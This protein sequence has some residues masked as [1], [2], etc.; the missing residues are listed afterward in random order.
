VRSV[1]TAGGRRRGQRGSITVLAVAMAAV[2]L[3]VGGTLAAAVGLVR[4][5][6]SAESAADLAAL[7]GARELEGARDGCVAAARIAAANDAR[8][9]SCRVD[10]SDVVVSV[11]VSGPHWL[12]L[13]ADLAAEARAGP[14]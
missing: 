11:T 12:G 4:A 9:T 14:G 2:L 8:L 3:F 10:G 13:H 5:H 1:A 6:R 7:A